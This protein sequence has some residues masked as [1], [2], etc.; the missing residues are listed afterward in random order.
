MSKAVAV[1]SVIIPAIKSVRIQ[2][3]ICYQDA[4]APK[5]L[6]HM[7]GRLENKESK[8]LSL[9]ILLRKNNR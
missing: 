8:Q 2:T 5:S 4:E 1:A 6:Q 3:F 9:F 7:Q